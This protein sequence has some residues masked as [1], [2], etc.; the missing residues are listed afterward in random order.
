MRRIMVDYIRNDSGSMS[1]FVS[2]L[3][4]IMLAVGG[5]GVDVMRFE[6]DRARLQSALDRAVLAAADLDQ[7]QDPKAVVED[8]LAK[9]GLLQNLKE[10]KVTPESA[11]QENTGPL[12][13]R[14][15]EARAESRF[16]THFMH[17]SGVD[18]LTAQAGSIAEESI[19]EVEISLV[20]DVSGSMNNYNRLTNLKVAAKDFID[21]MVQNTRDGDLSISIVPYATQVSV[22]ETIF[23]QY[24]TEGTNDYSRCINFNGSDFNSTQMLTKDADSAPTFERTMHFDPWYTTDRRDNGKILGDGGGLP[25]CEAMANREIMAFQKDATTLKNY[26]QDFVARGNTSLDIGM[27]W[28]AAMLDPSFDPVVDAMVAANEVPNAFSDRP[29]AYN[30]GDTLKIIV[31]MTDGNNTSQYYIKNDYREGQSNIWWN[32]EEETY[33]VYNPDSGW[34]Y[35]VDAD[36]YNAYEWQDH[37]YGNGDSHWDCGSSGCWEDTN[38]PEDGEAVRLDYPELWARTSLWYNVKEHYYPWM[39]DS[40]ARSEWVY[41]VRGYK[42]DNT[43]DSRTQAICDAA[44]D[45]NI[46]VYTIAFEAPPEGKSILEYCASSDSHYYDVDGLEIKDA[47]DSIGS[48][49]RKLRLTQ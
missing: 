14:I 27:K 33:S 34:Y 40:S 7:T 3:L 19:G 5:L 28:G 30:A 18:F 38:E 39:N 29:A 11:G 6:R 41:G 42:N 31:L 35:W 49:I 2:F 12:G 47:F 1:L 10:V 26:I 20:L 37:P 9:E 24:K 16:P 23:D 46:I 13:F 45:S 8:Y 32:E 22:P 17:L 48:S 44:K 36:D 25:V 15:V 21:Q 4:L 43:K